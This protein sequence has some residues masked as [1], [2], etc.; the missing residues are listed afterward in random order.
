MCKFI[1]K[2]LLK[3]KTKEVISYG[4]LPS[5]KEVLKPK[6][7]IKAMNYY[8][9]HTQHVKNLMKE[10]FIACD[11]SELEDKNNPM[12]WKPGHWLWFFDMHKK[13]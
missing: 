5:V 2:I 9:E 8:R 4:E 10:S 6:Q 1:K 13:K 11:V 12:L 7:I 3:Q